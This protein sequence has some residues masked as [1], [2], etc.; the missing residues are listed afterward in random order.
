MTSYLL[1]L[2]TYHLLLGMEKEG[3]GDA[4]LLPEG[5]QTNKQKPFETLCP[6]TPPGRGCLLTQEGLIVIVVDYRC[7]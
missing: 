3:P 4:V 2:Q 5:E 7:V 6:A 1:F